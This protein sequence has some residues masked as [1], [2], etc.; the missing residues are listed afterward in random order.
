M[1]RFTLLLALTSGCLFDGEQTRGLPCNADEE[2]GPGLSCSDHVCGGLE[3]EVGSSDEASGTEAAQS[4][5]TAIDDESSAATPQGCTDED[6]ECL[7]GNI[8]RSCSDGKL[9][10]TDCRGPC[11]EAAPSLGCHHYAAESRDTCF[12]AN[13]RPECEVSNVYTC[14]PGNALGSCED[15]FL[16]GT[17]CDD[18]CADAGYGGGDYCGAAQEGTGD[19]CYCGNTCTDGA[20]RCTNGD[21]NAVCSGGQWYPESCDAICRANGYDL[22]LG[23]RYDPGWAD[24]GCSCW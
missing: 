22:S 3:P 5:E 23:C 9:S 11:G 2:C 20:S 19:I 13:A 1:R 16:D 18:I 17:D 15:G 14:A 6:T 10:T 24:S 4:D 21:T 8:L 12:C 7:D